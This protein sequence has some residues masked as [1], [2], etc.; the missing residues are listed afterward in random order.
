MEPAP[1]LRRLQRRQAA[2]PGIRIGLPLL[3][4]GS[5]SG[6][7]GVGSFVRD[8]RLKRMAQA[9]TRLP[10]R[11]HSP[12]RKIAVACAFSGDVLK[13]DPCPRLAERANSRRTRAPRTGRKT[14]LPHRHR[15]G[16]PSTPPRLT[17]RSCRTRRNG[18][19]SSGSR[20]VH[21][22]RTGLSNV[23]SAV[24]ITPRR[25]R[26]LAASSRTTASRR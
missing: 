8:G 20:L 26:T 24:A 21:P 25:D 2:T 22:P 15:R 1:C 5:G 9:S 10:A 23:R 3:S 4:P 11:T 6:S 12:A 18:E 16:S 13:T 17:R 19:R 7:T 14:G